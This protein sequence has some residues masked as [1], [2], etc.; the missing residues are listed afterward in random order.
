MENCSDTEMK[1]RIRGVSIHMEDFDFYFGVA[2]G[3]TLLRHSDNLSSTLQK[4]EMS[5]AQAQSIVAMT[6][7][8]LLSIR[9][10][11]SFSLFW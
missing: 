6:M 1:A 10:E 5:A 8:T 3:E 2:L 11:D 7:K 4:E 9:N